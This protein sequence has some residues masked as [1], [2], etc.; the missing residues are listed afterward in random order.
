VNIDLAQLTK[1]LGLPV[2]R[3]HRLMISDEYVFLSRGE[4]PE[5]LFQPDVRQNM[6]AIG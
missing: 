3:V 1:C 2:D 6:P 4:P 5:P